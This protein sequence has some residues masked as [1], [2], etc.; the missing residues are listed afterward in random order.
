MKYLVAP[1]LWHQVLSLEK[2]NEFFQVPG[3][4]LLAE[5]LTI[6][7]EKMVSSSLTI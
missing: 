6:Q 1:T 7:S 5:A 2:A 3:V 4:P